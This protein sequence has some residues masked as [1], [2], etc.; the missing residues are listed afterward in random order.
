M[1]IFAKLGTSVLAVGT[2]L[3]ATPAMA[4][5]HAGE[6][7]ERTPEA[8]TE[9]VAAANQEL[10]DLFDIAARAAWVNSIRSVA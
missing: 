5:N 8:A 1:K 4:D 10:L 3:A 2:A 9:F 6:S 7:A